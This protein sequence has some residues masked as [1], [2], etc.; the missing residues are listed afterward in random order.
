MFNIS[1]PS[2]KAAALSA[3]VIAGAGQASALSFHV[4][5]AGSAAASADPA[6]PEV[7]FKGSFQ[8]VDSTFRYRSGGGRGPGERAYMDAVAAEGS[9][10]EF[11][12]RV[13]DLST[14]S[15]ELSM[16]AGPNDGGA[17]AVFDLSISKVTDED[18][19]KGVLFEIQ[20]MDDSLLDLELIDA[21]DSETAL[22]LLNAKAASLY[23]N[24][25]LTYATLYNATFGREFDGSVNVASYFD[26]T[27]LFDSDS[28]VAFRDKASFTGSVSAVPLPATALLLPT[29]LAALGFAGKRRRKAA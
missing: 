1:I 14:F 26:E 4:D 10:I 2:L 20:F 24:L 19:L 12:G 8:P 5:F 16:S 21:P 15:T 18:N 27:I 6:A 9:T 3:L 22:S 11:D 23:D 13:Y 25:K 28:H 7:R 17:Y 29:A